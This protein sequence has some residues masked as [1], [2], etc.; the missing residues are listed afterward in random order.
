MRLAIKRLKF[1]IPEKPFGNNSVKFNSLIYELKKVTKTAGAES[2]KFEAAYSDVCHAARSI[3]Y[4]DGAIASKI[5]IRALAI[6]LPMIQRH[7]KLRARLFEKIYQLSPKPSSLL[8]DAMHQYFLNRF[9]EIEV[10]KE[11]GYWL[12]W[13][14][15]KKN[16]SEEYDE[17][18]ISIDGP[19]WLACRAVEHGLDFAQQLT[20][21]KLHN[22]SSGRFMTVSK[23]IYYVEK[24]QSIPANKEHE[25]LTELQKRSVFESRYDENKKIGHCALKI[26]IERAPQTEVSESWLNTIIAIAGDPRIPNNHLNYI[27]WWSH[28]GK[29][30]IRKVCGWLSKLDLKLFLEALE[31]YSRI[32]GNDELQ[33]MYPA[34][35]HFLDGLFDA[36]LITHTRL[37]LS[38]NASDYLKN[39]Y[40]LKH[41]PNYSNVDGTKSI[42]H[43][44]LGD[45]HIIEG[46]H[47][48]YLR[49]YPRLDGSATVFDYNKNFETYTGLT[50]QMERLMV[51]KGCSPID[52]IAH[53]P[54]SF[55]WQ[56]RA[57]GALKSI[58][59]NIKMKDVLSASQYSSYIRLFGVDR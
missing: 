35:K 39:N 37:Y 11:L 49:V 30:E 17:S 1:L 56:R 58:G 27:K 20:E 52:K 44:Q 38:Y 25:L 24:L 12:L 19:K 31:N 3:G 13:A 50:S 41:L 51:N 53:H 46:S 10:K 55:S 54:V 21:L 7:V 4:V 47:T 23:R 34:R 36:G 16:T 29:D 14:R 48:C 28:I 32:S 33:R 40:P 42:I 2:K 59:V 9:D 8:V 15:R 45:R 5:H 26:L 43:V 22:F 18:L 57:V 6:A